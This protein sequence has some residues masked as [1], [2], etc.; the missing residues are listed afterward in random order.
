[1]NWVEAIARLSADNQGFVIVTV[2]AAEG[3]SPRNPKSKMV[4]TEQTS[5]DTIGGGHLEFSAIQQARKLLL[6]RQSGNER[7]VYHLGNDLA[8][9]C[10]GRVELLYEPFLACD[11]HIALFGAGHVGQAIVRILMDIPCRVTWFDTRQEVLSTSMKDCG[12]P[13][14]VAAQLMESPHVEVEGLPSGTWYLIMTHNHAMDWDLVEAVL[15]RDDFPYCGLIGSR[16]KAVSFRKKLSRKGFSEAEIARLTSPIG[17]DLGGGK[18][19]MEVAVS[20][21][22]QLMAQYYGVTHESTATT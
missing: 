8:Q 22:A 17:V 21:V 16:S 3:S 9:C 10:G 5:Y 4:V 14:N 18:R 6:Q 15:A 12:M 7:Q 13:G 19:P 1:M 2:L 11:F 20:V